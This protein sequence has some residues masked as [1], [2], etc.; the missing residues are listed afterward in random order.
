M[1][2]STSL[3]FSLAI[4]YLL[5]LF[6]IAYA[7]EHGW[8]P[9]RWVRHP[10]V[11][12]L[13]LG[14]YVSTWGLFGVL[15]FAQDHGFN[16]LTYY[17]GLAGA[18][19]LAPV[20]LQP[21]FRLARAHQ[22]ASL[23]D[24]LS[25]RFR[26]QWVGTATALVMFFS[27]MPLLTSQIQ[28]VAEV[29]RRLTGESSNTLMGIL[30]CAM[31]IVFTWLFGARAFGS[32]HRENDGLVFAIAMES[33]L[34]LIAI[35]A[36]ALYAY[37]G[38]LDGP[39]G[40]NQWLSA[41][42]DALQSMFQ[43]LQ[44]SH[45]HSLLLV[46]C[47]S[48]VVLPCMYQIAFTENREPRNLFI[49][50]WAFPLYLLVMA[51]G[52]PIL[53]WASRALGLH[54]DPSFFSVE[55]ALS[56]G[57]T[58]LVLTLFLGALASSSGILIISTLAISNMLLNHL[59][60]P[61]KGWPRD[62]ALY[63]ETLRQ[64]RLLI[65]FVLLCAYLFSLAPGLKLDSTALT[66]LT[67]V[68][69]LQF[70]PG[71]LATVYWPRATKNGFLVGLGLGIIIWI[72]YL[73]IP[74]VL[75]YETGA[76]SLLGLA[77]HSRLDDWQAAGI[78]ATLANG[79]ALVM[80]S[81]LGTQTEADVS[82]AENCSV[83]NIS[84]SSRWSLEASSVEAFIQSL[85]PALGPLTAEREVRMACHDLN[86]ASDERRPYAL[87]RLRDQLNAN[88]S[89]LLGPSLA[90]EIVD[91]HLPQ[92]MLSQQPAED[93][94]FIE[95]RLE[96]YR[97]RLSGLAAELDNLRRFHRQ[98]LLDL[99]LGVCT[100][101]GDLEIMSWNLAMTRITGLTDTEVIGSQLSEL[102]VP[103]GDTLTEFFVQPHAQS[104][105]HHVQR[106]GDSQWLNLHR[107][108][109][110]EADNSMVLVM[111]DVTA[112]EKLE[113]QL[114]HNERLAGIGRLAA[115]V[116]HEI[117]NP[118]T[119]IACLAQNLRAEHESDR[120]IQDTANDIITQTQ[121]VSKI[122]QSLVGFSRSETA[123]G[124]S[125]EAVPLRAVMQEAIHLMQLD[126]DKPAMRWQLDLDDPLCAW[127]DAQRLCQVFINLLSNARDASP[128]GSAVV[129][130]GSHHGG[131]VQIEIED[132]GHGLPESDLRARLFEPFVT[133]KPVGAGTGLGLALVHGIISTHD[134]RIQLIDKRDYDQGQGVIVQIQLPAAPTC[135]ED[136]G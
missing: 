115:G 39:D 24:L 37:W 88:L 34:K 116:A 43:P 55:L 50:T 68:G 6:L 132:Y 105:R 127:G 86:L 13:A 22:L 77:S 12:I 48:A 54:G 75:A 46:F 125:F 52:I 124:S 104:T 69:V 95:S 20:F 2:F 60:L 99:P 122:V 92:K 71:L 79:I 41:H 11:I 113:S 128:K 67:F 25:Y 31:L 123:T 81:L 74:T 59:V 51:M 117:G 3:I 36:I 15:Q 119:G 4:G 47:F 18:F 114:H 83:D 72:M 65:S 120:D 7:S 8:I 10:A 135:E 91:K 89:G 14:V 112:L 131:R 126:P 23:A 76:S 56:S 62:D 73:L 96:D 27:V 70:A 97:H 5:I 102:P 9:L 98:T 63:Q 29:G 100:L 129:V 121:R 130:R 103:W 84:R 118:I 21:L 101:T 26:S 33:V 40:L 1:I 61:L 110:G 106:Q 49:A 107:G 136:I 108:L 16:Y 111:E 57:S 134:G 42:P 133:T 38:V 109:I 93:I 28:T 58:V 78:F 30:F 45:W 17:L 85:T 80:T 66:M 19:L 90:E 82:V 44:G 32:R 87:R 94:H 35:V 64:R 53:L